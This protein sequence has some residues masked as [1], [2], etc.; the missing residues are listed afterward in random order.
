MLMLKFGLLFSMVLT[1]S[2]VF[3]DI[4][5]CQGMRFDPQ[6]LLNRVR[7]AEEASALLNAELASAG[8][9]Q[10]T[11]ERI[12]RFE[13]FRFEKDYNPKNVY[14]YGIN[15]NVPSCTIAL[16]Q[17]GA[18]SF[19]SYWIL[20]EEDGQRQNPTKSDLKNL[21]PTVL[22]HN[23]NS[24]RFRMKALNEINIQKR[25]IEIRTEIVNGNCRVR[26]YVDL[27]NGQ[28][29]SLNRIFANI[30]RFLGVPT[31]VSSL[32]VEGRDSQ[33]GQQVTLTFDD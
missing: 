24:V 30:S 9:Q 1:S 23:P 20:G 27:D 4:R 15:I 25:E 29:I 14:H 8:E 28:E 12:Q 26:G 32:R 19:N 6:E 2:V 17:N 18:P 33:T 22:S 3:A 10:E 5:F 7:E 31:G 16:R 21:G 11:Q 13:L